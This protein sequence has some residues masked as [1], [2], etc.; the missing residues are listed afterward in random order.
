MEG[1]TYGKMLG[2]Q[3]NEMKSVYIPPDSTSVQQNDPE[4]VSDGWAL[5]QSEEWK[6]KWVTVFDLRCA[7]IPLLSLLEWP[8]VYV[9][10]KDG[11][12]A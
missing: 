1:Y 4:Q 5:A 9:L 6:P 8:N 10:G 7:P 11:R 3:R 12:P 2:T